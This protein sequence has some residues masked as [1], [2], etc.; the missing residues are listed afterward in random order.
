MFTRLDHDWI[1]KLAEEE[2]GIKF[3]DITN[4]IE[5][6]SSCGQTKHYLKNVLQLI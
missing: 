3:E 1:L 4:S 5:Y 6:D 2:Q